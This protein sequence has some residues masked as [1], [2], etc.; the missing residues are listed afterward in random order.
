MRR[1]RYCVFC[2]SLVT[3]FL[4]AVEG[5]LLFEDGLKNYLPVSAYPLMMKQIDANP[6]C[7][8]GTFE[9]RSYF[10]SKVERIT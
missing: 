1:K 3:T 8:A 5:Q 7:R 4:S 9:K 2:F 10:C 6:N